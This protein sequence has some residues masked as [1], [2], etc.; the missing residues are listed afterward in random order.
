VSDEIRKTSPKLESVSP[1]ELPELFS[2]SKTKTSTSA[3][4]LRTKKPS[5]SAANPAETQAGSSTG[6][7][8]EEKTKESET[9]N[10]GVTQVSESL[11][12]NFL[13]NF[14][15]DQQEIWT[16]PF[17]VRS[18]DAFWLV[19][20]A[21]ITAGLIHS[22]ADV[23][24]AMS[25]S[26]S[27]ANTSKTF[28]DAGVFALG[29]MVGGLYV[30]GH[31]EHNDHARETGV[32]GTEALLNS[33]AVSSALKYSLGR[34]RPFNTNGRGRFFQG[35]DSFPSTH[36]IAAWSLAT[37]L[38]HEYPGPLTKFGVYGLA[39]A[40]SF[41]RV[42][43]RQ[44]FPSDV[45]IGS[46]LGWGIGR[47]VYNR[48][49]NADV[50]GV[51]IGNFSRTKSESEARHPS[52]SASIYVPLE[53][54]VYPVLDRLSSMGFVRSAF[55]GL[56]PWTRLECA[57]LTE[58]AE[59]EAGEIDGYSASARLI[60]SLKQEFAGELDLL[61]GTADPDSPRFKLESIY[62]RVTGI[63][64]PPLT[65]GYHFGQTIYNDYG[66]PYREGFNSINGVSGWVTQGRWAFYARGEYQHAPSAPAI[67][68]VANAVANT[69]DQ[70]PIQPNTAFNEVNR[71]RLL[72][73]YAA[74]TLN[75]WQFSFGKQ[76]LWWG[77]GESGAMNYSNNAEPVTMFRVNRVIPVTLPG[78]GG[79]LGPIRAEFFFGQLSGQKFFR[80]AAGSFGPGFSP[81]PLI[82]G[83]KFSLKLTPDLEIGMS[84]T[85]VFG[86]PGFPI[87]LKTILR[88]FTLSNTIP[89]EISDPGDRRAGFDFRYRIPGLRNW[90]TL[91]NDSVAEDEFSPI[92]Y[93]R[94]SAMNPGIYLARIPG[95]Q[96]LDLRAEGFYTDLPGL[97]SVGTYYYN[98][99][100]L[101]GFTNEGNSLGHPV[102]RQ[103]SGYKITTT[104][105]ASAQN[106][107]QLSYR[108]ARVSSEFIP[109]GNSVNDYYLKSNWVLSR[110]LSFLGSVQYENWRFPVLAVGQ[111]SNVTS[112]IQL[113]YRP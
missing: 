44:H 100:F 54:W 112:S 92:A 95:I 28:S 25:V 75:N 35:G 108:N 99:R 89:G 6:N 90:L 5:E 31:I 109:G 50:G 59:H 32:L 26:D 66:R 88:S 29:G 37:V 87:T 12:R 10:G 9:P 30:L 16:S 23:Y 71:L 33:L 47:Q 13:R 79:F 81:Q 7:P 97:Q 67:P 11:E 102:G 113:T 4:E 17:K 68:W 105:W 53:S 94:R 73:A 2:N 82:H 84:A 8:V 62:T 20:A 45:V 27:H 57:R 93:P 85:T 36:A 78:W 14:A 41:A 52:S 60:S 110:Q 43:G 107:I 48:H 1:S 63:S 39:S 64:G 86:G 83:E 106:S 76:S 24:S 51:D 61:D 42:T 55:S 72:D 103:G 40:I 46:A 15:R 65:D 69:I 3:E 49:H 74:Y 18:K 38:A 98:T 80:S 70:I 22:D 91:Y 77:P 58:E 104:F 56:R 111:K 21:G 34:D 19:P 96:H 101:S